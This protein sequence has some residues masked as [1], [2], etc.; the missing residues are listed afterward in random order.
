MRYEHNYYSNFDYQNS[1]DT[2]N[3]TPPNSTTTTFLPENPLKS[4]IKLTTDSLKFIV[5]DDDGIG[6]D[7]DGSSVGSL[8]VSNVH[9]HSRKKKF[10]S[11]YI[12]II[13]II[14][15]F[16]SFGMV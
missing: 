2:M 10:S 6:G 8:I 9:S 16:I 3:G 5:N 4:Q 15:H 14:M 11:F 12:A 1:I 13:T 7:G